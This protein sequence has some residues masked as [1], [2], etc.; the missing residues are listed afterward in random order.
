MVKNPP[1]MQDTWFQSLNGEDPLEEGMATHSSTLALENPVDRGAWRAT[2][3]GVTEL[4]TTAR[5][6]GHHE[7]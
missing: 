3:H 7:M 2:L 4:D 5:H 6:P 1:E